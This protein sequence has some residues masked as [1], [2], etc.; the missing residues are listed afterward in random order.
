MPKWF[1][2]EGLV[3]IMILSK[4][5]GD[6]TKEIPSVINDVKMWLFDPPYNIG[7]KYDAIKDNKT[8]KEYLDFIY[9]TCKNMF[10]RSSDNSSMFFVNYPE[11][12]ARLLVKIESTGWKLNQ[13]LTWVYPSNI[14][15]SKNKFTRASRGVLWFT[16]GNPIV[17]IKAVQQP[18]KNP[19][20]KRIKQK[21]ANG[22][23]GVN[24]YD[25]WNINLRKNV[26]KG[27]KGYSNQLPF[28]LIKRMILTTTKQNDIVADLNAGSGSLYEVSKEHN[29]NCH[30]MD[31]NPGCLKI[32]ES[33]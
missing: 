20:D 32:W 31:I 16:K 29:R 7:F 2:V 12:A 1:I 23:K 30:L 33:I 24:L 18:Y 13:W 14:G 15:F 4:H 25:Y 11:I 21:I 22:S 3:K 10:S 9:K 17:D 27:F 28:E 5:I 8:E 6:S 26:S 19:N